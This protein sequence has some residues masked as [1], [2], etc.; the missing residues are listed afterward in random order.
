M[1]ATFFDPGLREKRTPVSPQRYPSVVSNRLVTDVLDVPAVGDAVIRE[2]LGTVATIGTPGATV[3]LLE[4]GE[5]V[6]FP[7]T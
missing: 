4:L 6:A 1:R 5:L 7:L 3:Y 2:G